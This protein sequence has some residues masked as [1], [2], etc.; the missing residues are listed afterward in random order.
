[1]KLEEN[2]ATGD[3]AELLG[4]GRI[5]KGQEMSR[6]QEHRCPSPGAK[7]QTWGQAAECPMDP[8]GPGHLAG[9]APQQ[10]GVR[11][12]PQAV[13]D[14]EKNACTSPRT[15]GAVIQLWCELP[16]NK[17]LGGLYSKY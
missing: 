6:S 15:Q 12:T 7:E 13:N 17:E 11:K 8:S 4:W 16:Q 1:M 5:D 14:G 9:G 3:K 10:G 2:E